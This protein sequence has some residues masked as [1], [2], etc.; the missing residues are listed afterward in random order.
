MS[1]V[2]FSQFASINRILYLCF[3]SAL[4]LLFA[5]SQVPIRD[6]GAHLFDYTTVTG[7]FKHD[8]DPAGP[9]YRAVCRPGSQT[10]INYML[11][12]L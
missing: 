4:A 5:M 1:H 2:R 6:R 9:E 7:Y 10:A 11:K 8:E 3:G 12:E